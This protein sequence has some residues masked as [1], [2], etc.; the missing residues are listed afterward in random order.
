M[1]RG[2][3]ALS[4]GVRGGC[5]PNNNPKSTGQNEMGWDGIRGD[6]MGWDIVWFCGFVEV[7]GGDSGGQS[8]PVDGVGWGG[9]GG[10]AGGGMGWD[11]MG[12]DG[13]GWDGV[14][15]D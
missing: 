12:W 11:G 8:S 13:M 5:D 15:W 10:V 2:F 9:W 6:K 3:V 4:C 7:A 14:G 1:S